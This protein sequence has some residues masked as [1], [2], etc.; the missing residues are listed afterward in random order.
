MITIT[1]HLLLMVVITVLL[2]IGMFKD[3]D[4]SLDFGGI[5][6]FIVLVLAWLI[7][8]GIFLW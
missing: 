1:W 3:S 8:G 2:I 6:Y 5:L 4:G 7:Y